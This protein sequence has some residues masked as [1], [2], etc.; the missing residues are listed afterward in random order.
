[1]RRLIVLQRDQRRN[2][3]GWAGAQ[4]TGQLVDRGLAAAGRKD[5]QDIA[6]IDRSGYRLQL[7]GTQT[8]ESEPRPSQ[9]MNRFGAHASST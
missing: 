9:L 8:L 4:Q 7:S 1:M 5:G 2:D 3:D 6:T